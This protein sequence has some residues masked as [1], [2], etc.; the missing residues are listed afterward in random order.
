[1]AQQLGVALPDQPLMVRVTQERR[2][3]GVGGKVNVR[4]AKPAGTLAIWDHLQQQVPRV[5]VV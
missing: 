1:M 3:A 5:P 4:G 2:S